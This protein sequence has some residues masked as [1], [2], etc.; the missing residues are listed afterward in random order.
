MIIAAIPDLRICIPENF[1]C[2][3]NYFETPHI[4]ILLSL[5]GTFILRNIVALQIDPKCFNCG[6]FSAAFFD[7]LQFKI[8][9]LMKSIDSFLEVI[10]KR[11]HI[12]KKYEQNDLT[13]QSRISRKSNDTRVL[14]Y[15]IESFKSNLQINDEI[16]V[17][18]DLSSNKNIH[19][20]LC[21]INIFIQQLD[22]T[23][24]ISKHYS[25]FLE[26][27]HIFFFS[28]NNSTKNYIILEGNK[29]SLKHV[30]NFTDDIKSVTR[31]I[32][33]ILSADQFDLNDLIP[34]IDLLEKIGKKYNEKPEFVQSFYI[35]EL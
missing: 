15:L 27:F 20:N 13:G 2:F 7:Q 14:S 21:D 28:L 11:E 31:E 34:F 6:S 12:Q 5:A 35:S 22:K 19:D 8:N 33:S 4:Q 3:N 17:I 25:H 10:L 18:L 9:N 1:N 29:F 30:I 16:N 26:L 24:A 23:E 32:S